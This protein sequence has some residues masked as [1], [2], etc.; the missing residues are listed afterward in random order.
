MEGHTQVV[1]DCINISV[2]H[3]QCGSLCGTCHCDTS[4]KLCAECANVWIHTV[5][6]R[7]REDLVAPCQACHLQEVAEDSKP[8]CYDCWEEFYDDRDDLVAEVAELQQVAQE[9]A[10]EAQEEWAQEAQE[11]QETQ[12][13]QE[14]Q[15]WVQEWA[16]EYQQS[17][18]QK[19]T[20]SG[21]DSDSE[22][23]ALEDAYGAA[24]IAYSQSFA[25]A[26]ALQTRPLKLRRTTKANIKAPIIRPPLLDSTEDLPFQTDILDEETKRLW[27]NP[28]IDEEKKTIWITLSG[29]TF[30]TSLLELHKLSGEFMEAVRQKA[31]SSL[32][33]IPID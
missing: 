4:D 13:A 14:A 16:Q 10:Q 6:A 18:E 30:H 24:A 19:Q 12:E 2:C 5:F 3:S 17:R 29:F 11:A 7:R 25:A 32:T 22:K 31:I 15:E 9:E 8:L 33:I 27:K 23:E 21:Q 28:Q 26:A 20:H 1:Q